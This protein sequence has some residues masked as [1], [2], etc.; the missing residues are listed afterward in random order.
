MKYLKGNLCHE[1]H[2]YI[3]KSLHFHYT[4]WGKRWCFTFGIWPFQPQGLPRQGYSY[5]FRTHMPIFSFECGQP[6][7]RFMISRFLSS[8]LLAKHRETLRCFS[9]NKT[10]RHG[11]C[12]RMA[13]LCTLILLKIIKKRERLL[14]DSL[15]GSTYVTR[16]LMSATLCVRIEL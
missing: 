9:A 12:P 6:H 14:E 3:Y 5:K 8:S 16:V 2:Y 1:L 7:L 13:T 11:T 10:P 4:N 15:S